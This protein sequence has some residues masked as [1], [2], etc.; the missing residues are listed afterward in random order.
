M[1][2]SVKHCLN[3]KKT[4]LVFGFLLPLAFHFEFSEETVSFLQKK[5]VISNQLCGS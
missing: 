4:H 5:L 2:L 3:T 1:S